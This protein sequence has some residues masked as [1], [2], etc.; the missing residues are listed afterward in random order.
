MKEYFHD[1]LRINIKKKYKS[2]RKCAIDTGIEQSHF[3]QIINGMQ[4]PSPYTLSLI[5]K[6]LGTTIDE[7]KEVIWKIWTEKAASGTKHKF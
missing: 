7:Q 5:F 6:V 2:F 4:Y 1:W 3:Y